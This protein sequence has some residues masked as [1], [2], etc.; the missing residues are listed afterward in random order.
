MKISVIK[1]L[2]EHGRE[3][4]LT[5]NGKRYSFTFGKNEEGKSIVAFCEFNK[6]DIECE[7]I[8]ELLSSKYDSF[9]LTDMIE[10]LSEEDLEIF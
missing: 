1:D 9:L 5:Y 7:T 2:L 3:I 8:D 6:D 4:E 10:S